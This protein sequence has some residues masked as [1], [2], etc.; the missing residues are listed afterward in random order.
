MYMS[1]TISNTKLSKKESKRK[2]LRKLRQ[3]K[4]TEYYKRKKTLP[5]F[6]DIYEN[7]N[8]FPS[9][10]SRQPHSDKQWKKLVE[11]LQNFR[12]EE[13]PDKIQLFYVDGK[14]AD[15][16]DEQFDEVNMLDIH[17]PMTKK[18]LEKLHRNHKKWAESLGPEYNSQFDKSYHQFTAIKELPSAFIKYVDALI[19]AKN[20]I[21]K[22][23][24]LPDVLGDYVS[25]FSMRNESYEAKMGK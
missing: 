9:V 25:R 4:I 22:P 7:R 16:L 14:D 17:K 15:Y 11:T 13:E 6:N 21:I 2:T 5:T 8:V 1:K 10:K 3:P 12:D 20:H 19:Y 24:K 18:Y 23:G